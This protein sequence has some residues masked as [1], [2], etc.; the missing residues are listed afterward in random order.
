MMNLKQLSLATAASL[1][2]CATAF[3]GGDQH[4]PAY[5]HSGYD[6][7]WAN[8]WYLG[9]GANGD[10]GMS[11]ESVFGQSSWEGWPLGGVET[12]FEKSENNVGFDVYV[13]RKVS[14]HFAFEMGYT[15]VGNQNF[16]GH[17]SSTST[18]DT[19]EVQ[20]WNVHGV[21]LI[22]LPIGDYFN[23]FAKGGVAY[24]QNQ[25]DIDAELLNNEGV[26][27]NE[28]LNTF[29]LT[30]G[31]GIELTYDQFGV[32]GEYTV[33]APNHNNQNN[34]YISDIIGVNLFYRFM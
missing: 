13:G 29:A 5:T 20:Q 26:S 17:N 31:A 15:W 19:I 6:S 2:L 32:R 22:H 3:A 34:F 24:Y 11:D 27:G 33:I 1:A 7:N 10:A 21:G 4:A 30:Y 23:V 8:G 25:T 28:V 18:K 12:D 14:K 9:A 16:K